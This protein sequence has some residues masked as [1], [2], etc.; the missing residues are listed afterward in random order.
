MDKESILGEFDTLTKA[1]KQHSTMVK[2]C[3]GFALAV[4]VL[5]L[6]WGFGV[7]ISALDKVVV[8]SNSG[9]YLQ[10]ESI[11]TEALFSAR[12]QTTCE[13]VTR[14]A[15]SFD[16]QTIK[17]NQARAL[18]YGNSHDLNVIFQKYYNDRAYTDATNTGAVYNCTL[19]RVESIH[20]DNE[21]YEVKFTSI[22]TIASSGKVYRFRIYSEGKVVSTT[23]RYPE[24]V[25]GFIFSE[26]TQRAEAIANPTPTTNEEEQYG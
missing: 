3:L 8:I 26:L 6:I 4:V 15:N 25:T 5:V 12:I 2:L 23:P 24:N 19:E 22:L 10:T 17:A 13:Y 20:G 1:K 7:S 14:Y 11:N 16:R 21:P 9:E 18:F